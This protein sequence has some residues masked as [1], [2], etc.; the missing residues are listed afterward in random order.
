VIPS[1][2]P[3]ELAA[4]SLRPGAVALLGLLAACGIVLAWDRVPGWARRAWGSTAALLAVALLVR[5][6]LSLAVDGGLYDVFDAYRIVGSTLRAGHDVFVEPA[7]GLANYPPLVYWWWAAA[8]AVPADHPHLYA[9]LVRA[10]F[11]IADVGIALLLLRAAPPRIARRAAWMYA[12]SPV[13]AAVPTLHGQFEPWVLL[14][15]VAAVVV[16][17]ERPGA[18]G[19]LAG[20]AI[21]IKPWPVFFLIPLLATLPRR[22]WRPLLL[23]AAV[24]PLA[25]FAVYAPL[26]PGNLTTG[27]HRIATYQAHRQGF[28]T[29]LLFPDGVDAL[30]INV[31]NLAAG[32]LAIGAGVLAARQGRARSEALALSMLVLLTLSPTVSDQYLVWPLPFLLLAGRLRVAA[33]LGVAAVPAVAAVDLWTSQ[34]GAATPRPLFLLVTMATGAAAIWLALRPGASPEPVTA[35]ARPERVAVAA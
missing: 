29:S 31:L 22:T 8:S 32:A 15:L 34:D 27:L 23:G 17:P 19:L 25:A 11:W 14:P 1:D 33:L 20:L 7:L 13:A 24:V 3:L 12:L 35:A 26:H 18:A 2:G 21:A 9:A 30:P 16:L 10:P 5:A 4:G 6:L 28:G